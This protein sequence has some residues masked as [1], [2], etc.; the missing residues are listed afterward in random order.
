M[1]PV[2]C[3]RNEDIPIQPDIYVTHGDG[4][5]S[6]ED[7]SDWDNDITQKVSNQT[8]LSTD[9]EKSSLQTVDSIDRENSALDSDRIL[10][11]NDNLKATVLQDSLHATDV[12]ESNS[13]YGAKSVEEY[14]SSTEKR[15]KPVTKNAMKLQ[16]NKKPKPKPTQASSQLGS[17]FDI[18]SIEIKKSD[19]K[20]VPE[21]DFFE[22]MVPDIKSTTKTADKL[23]G[24]LSGVVKQTE[25]KSPKTSQTSSKLAY[26]T[27]SVGADMVGIHN[28]DK[29]VKRQ[30]FHI[31]QI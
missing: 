25:E 7:W 29:K 22:D 5:T 14:M 6:E 4:N 12:T 10:K 1:S 20:S 18:K 15:N 8:A 23:L 9:S 24:E 28:F 16:S 26:Q 31:F 2:F 30:L 27:D 17:E 21:F 11:K 3:Y 19:T 13:L